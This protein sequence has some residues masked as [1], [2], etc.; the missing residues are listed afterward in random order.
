MFS[1]FWSLTCSKEKPVFLTVMFNE[2]LER[3]HWISGPFRWTSPGVSESQLG[4]MTFL[5]FVK[6]NIKFHGLE[7]PTIYIYMVNVVYRLM[8][9]DPI[10]IFLKYSVAC[11]MVGVGL[12]CE[13]FFADPIFQEESYP[14]L[15]TFLWVKLVHLP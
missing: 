13:I 10:V 9:R 12:Y 5:F 11:K 4:R 1:K 7:P 6:W 14:P 2:N 3:I 8:S 15:Y